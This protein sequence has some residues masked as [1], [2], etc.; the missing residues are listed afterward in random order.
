MS[1]VIEVVDET[2][3]GIST[4]GVAELVR[5]V[6]DREGAQGAVVV[7]LV[8]EHV[9]TELNGR[10]R[11]L[12]EPTDVLSYCAEDDEISWPTPLPEGDFAPELGE[13]IVCPAVARRYAEEGG[14]ESSSQLAWTIIHGV[15]HVLGYDHERD[16]GEMRRREQALLAELGPLASTLS[17]PPDD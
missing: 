15:L 9:I 2:D 1:I 13:V 14:C 8:G 16:E 17:T 4:D 5:S 11:G 3:S 7:A 10:D 12:P 6:L